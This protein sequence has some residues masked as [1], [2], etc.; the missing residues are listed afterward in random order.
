MKEYP[1][2]KYCA[3]IHQIAQSHINKMLDLCAEADLAIKTT[4]VDNYI[5]LAQL[6]AQL[7][8]TL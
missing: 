8:Q 7:I 4:A 3:H 5:L 6:T 2:K 1:I